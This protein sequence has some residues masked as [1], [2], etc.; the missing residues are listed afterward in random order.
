MVEEHVEEEDGLL[1]V[2]ELLMRE[3]QE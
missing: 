1:E 3:V 2:I